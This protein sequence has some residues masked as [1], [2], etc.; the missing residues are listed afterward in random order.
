MVVYKMKVLS[1]AK[2][3]SDSEEG[4]NL[5]N[6][7]NSTAAGIFKKLSDAHPQASPAAQEVNN[8]MVNRI[9]FNRYMEH[10]EGEPALELPSGVD[11]ESDA[12]YALLKEAA[13]QYDA[14][15]DHR[16]DSMLDYIPSG[17]G[18]KKKRKSRRRKSSKKRKSK[19]RRRRRKLGARRRR[20]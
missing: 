3:F 15:V 2:K 10:T 17:G 14:M 18:N 16:W 1:V 11:A 7:L 6:K 4:I 8:Y 19:T 20:R 12:G 5:I 13:D 9:A